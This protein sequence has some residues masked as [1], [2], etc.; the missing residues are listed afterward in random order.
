[1]RD[2]CPVIGYGRRRFQHAKQQLT[3]YFEPQKNEFYE[4]YRFRETKQGE[5]ET[6]DS[7]H[8]KVSSANL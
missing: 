1:M 3:Q 7:F 4:V 2:F 6:L 5:A 8:T